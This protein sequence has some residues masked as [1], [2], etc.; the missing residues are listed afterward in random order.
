MMEEAFASGDTN[1]EIRHTKVPIS[2]YFGDG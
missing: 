2:T 1:L